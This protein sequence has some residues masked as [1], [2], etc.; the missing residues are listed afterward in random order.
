MIVF[1]L[2]LAYMFFDNKELLPARKHSLFYGILGASILVTAFVH[3]R[4]L[5]VLGMVVFAWIVSVWWG[6]LPQ[7]HKHLIFILLLI[8]LIVEVV[9][10]QQRDILS[11][12]F[13]PYLNKG[14]WV[15]SLVLFLAVFAY[16]RYPQLTFVN[17]VVV[18]LLIASLFV[19]VTGLFPGRDYLTL[20]DRPYV[21]MILFI[22]L[23]LLGG[24]GFA[25]LE[26]TVK[27]S[28]QR[29]C[30]VYRYGTGVGPCT[31]HLRVLSVKVLCPCGK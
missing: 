29:V 23:S 25:G 20:M 4:A 31:C 30:S 8:A 18:C 1:V 14:V 9:L 17:L 10:V 12:L 26:K 15:T 16:R 11:L 28:Y 2:S 19:P 21:E 6:R 27:S 5:I 24:L 7:L 3:S 22:P 13:D